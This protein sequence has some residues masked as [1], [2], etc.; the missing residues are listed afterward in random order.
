M[1]K[2]K[3]SLFDRASAELEVVEKLL[4]TVTDEM[5]IDNCTYHCQQCIEKLVK[6][7]IELEGKEYTKRHELIDVIDDL[8]DIELNELIAPIT[9]YVDGWISSVRYGS[10]IASSRKQVEIVIDVCRK[11]IEV[12]RKKIPLPEP[13][14]AEMETG[15]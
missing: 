11:A 1:K 9:S 4:P 6:F 7:S 13:P 3:V 10:G 2:K 15:K 8:E 12:V 14:E 5:M